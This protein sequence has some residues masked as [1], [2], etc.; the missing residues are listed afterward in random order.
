MRQRNV[1][2][3]GIG[4]IGG[5]RVGELDVDV[6]GVVRRGDAEVAAISAGNGYVTR[7]NVLTLTPAPVAAE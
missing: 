5:V 3:D 2:R 6:A 4:V 1:K 7:C